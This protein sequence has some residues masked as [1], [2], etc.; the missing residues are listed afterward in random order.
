[1]VLFRIIRYLTLLQLRLYREPSLH[2]I[3][4]KTIIFVQFLT[5]FCIAY[6]TQRRFYKSVNLWKICCG[7]FILVSFIYIV[8]Y[9]ACST[10]GTIIV[11]I[12]ISASNMVLF[13]I[14]RY[15]TL[16]QLRLYREP[17]LHQINYKT[18][19]FVQFLTR[20]CIAYA[21]Q[22]RF[23]CHFPLWS[24]SFKRWIVMSF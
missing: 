4:Y 23:Y 22:R 11:F 6:A 15:L 12:L 19:I 13:R 21:T 24:R 14:I 18:I 3:N 9:G 5:R 17:S 1:M 10:L 2:Q 20:F 7:N 8:C 16:L